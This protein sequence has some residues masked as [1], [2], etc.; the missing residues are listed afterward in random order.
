M[1]E[2]IS[3]GWVVKGNLSELCGFNG[4]VGLACMWSECFLVF[5]WTSRSGFFSVY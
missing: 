1:L 3:V 5:Q 4:L 2:G